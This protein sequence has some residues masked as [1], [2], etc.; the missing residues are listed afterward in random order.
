MVVFKKKVGSGLNTDHVKGK[1][2]LDID[3]ELRSEVYAACQR[4]EK[5]SERWLQ[6]N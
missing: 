5:A 2:D 6:K 1:R 4:K 3:V